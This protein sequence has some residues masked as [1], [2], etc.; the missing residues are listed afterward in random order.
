MAAV[1]DIHATKCYEAL[2]AIKDFRVKLSAEELR[3]LGLEPSHTILNGVEWCNGQILHAGSLYIPNDRDANSVFLSKYSDAIANEGQLYISENRTRLFPMFFDID[4]KLQQTPQSVDML[5]RMISHTQVRIRDYTATQLAA[6][7]AE[8]N[9]RRIAAIMAPADTTASEPSEPEVVVELNDNTQSVHVPDVQYLNRL[10]EPQFADL[11]EVAMT[12]IAIVVQKELQSFY[13]SVLPTDPIFTGYVATCAQ[14][15]DGPNITGAEHTYKRGMHLHFRNCI[16]DS[17]RAKRI[18]LGVIDRLRATFGGPYGVSDQD[19][20]YWTEVVDECVYTGS[21]L[22]MLFSLKAKNCNNVTCPSLKRRNAR[23]LMCASGADV[24]S[25]SSGRHRPSMNDAVCECGGKGKLRIDRSYRVTHRV[26]KGEVQTDI[27]LTAN[28]IS[29]LRMCTIRVP[30]DTILTE[31]FDAQGKPDLSDQYTIHEYAAQYGPTASQK[32]KRQYIDEVIRNYVAQ[33]DARHREMCQASD[34]AYR[35]N[36][37]IPL[38]PNDERYI[39]AKQLVEQSARYIH[40]DFSG[41]VVHQIKL[42]Q[43]RGK[44]LPSLYAYTTSRLCLNKTCYMQENHMDDCTRL[45]THTNRSSP[46]LYFA[47]HLLETGEAQLIQCC[48]SGSDEP[49][50]RRSQTKCSDWCRTSTRNRVILMDRSAISR[51]FY[52]SHEMDVREGWATAAASRVK[53]AREITDDGAF[54]FEHRETKRPRMDKKQAPP[55]GLP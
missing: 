50:F 8:Q 30:P 22:R 52:T 29:Q 41:V 21:G 18:R 14:S 11:F 5:Q 47:L 53:R 24:P 12:A 39:K 27:N 19:T 48:Y 38:L 10:T 42:N 17:T 36:G 44:A 16:V 34:V 6:Y 3:Q 4:C 25:S 49:N 23:E 13:P 40:P 54:R 46:T 15:R 7:I 32:I 51:A 35:D 55:A 43:T 33:A 26:I 28:P 45:G 9:R 20:R 2:G 37:F 31:G 1:S